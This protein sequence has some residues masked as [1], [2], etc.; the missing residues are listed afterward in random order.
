[1]G[2]MHRWNSA[3][4]ISTWPGTRPSRVWP[5]SGPWTKPGNWWVYVEHRAGLVPMRRDRLVVA[6]QQLVRRLRRAVV[7]V[8]ACPEGHAFVV[9]AE[10]PVSPA[11]PGVLVLPAC[12]QH[13]A[14]HPS[15]WPEPTPRL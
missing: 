13:V 9:P 12:W 3:K 15:T 1:M 14:T 8:E 6:G 10:L 11:G 2:R 5:T 7:L 4:G